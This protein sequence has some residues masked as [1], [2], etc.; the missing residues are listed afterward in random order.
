M[1]WMRV[2]TGRFLDA[3]SNGACEVVDVDAAYRNRDRDEEK[4][5]ESRKSGQ[6]SPE[7]AHAP[8]LTRRR[9]PRA[10]P[11]PDSGP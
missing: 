10:S 7:Q 11:R 1:P 6:D 4:K 5:E 3:L 9:A 8:I 2:V